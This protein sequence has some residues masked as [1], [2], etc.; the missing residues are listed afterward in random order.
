[1]VNEVVK[2]T[3]W[4]TVCTTAVTLFFL[5]LCKVDTKRGL[6]GHCIEESPA[7]NLQ[8]CRTKVVFNPSRRPCVYPMHLP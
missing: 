7:G 3:F 1:M 8:T 2:L 5:L 6:S 4:S